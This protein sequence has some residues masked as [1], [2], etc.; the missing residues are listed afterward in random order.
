MRP[1]V[2]CTEPQRTHTRNLTNKYKR[3]KSHTHV[4]KWYKQ[5]NREWQKSVST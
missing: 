4:Y 3:T 1:Q 5:Y 2:Y